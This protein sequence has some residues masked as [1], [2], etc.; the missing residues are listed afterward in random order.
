MD[1][2]IKFI[3]RLTAFL[4]LFFILALGIERL[5]DSPD[6]QNFSE[7]DN[8]HKAL[9]DGADIIYFGDSA[10]K[11][12]D[13]NDVDMR[14]MAQ[15]LEDLLNGKQELITN[16]V[17]HYK[18]VNTSFQSGRFDLFNISGAI[19]ASDANESPFKYLGQTFD[20]NQT[21]TTRIA[22]IQEPTLFLSKMN[23]FS[24][25]YSIYVYRKNMI[26]SHI[27][28]RRMDEWGVGYAS[29]IF[30]KRFRFV[31][32][33]SEGIQVVLDSLKRISDETWYD[34]CVVRD[35]SEL[36]IRMYV[37]GKLDNAVPDN[38]K[39]NLY[40]D[41]DILYVGAGENGTRLFFNG[42]I[43][44]LLI[45]N[46]SLSSKEVLTIPR[47]E[48]KEQ[49]NPIIKQK[50]QSNISLGDNISVHDVSYAGYHLGLFEA[51]IDDIKSYQH[52]P[53][54]IIIPINMKLFSLPWVTFPHAQF[55][56]EINIIRNSQQNSAILTLWTRIYYLFS[57]NLEAVQKENEKW[58]NE[59]IY[60]D[61]KV[62][63]TAKDCVYTFVSKDAKNKADLNYKIENEFICRY[64][65]SLNLTNRRLRSLDTL[66]RTC[67][68]SGITPII[69]I[70]P[71][72]YDIGL[73]YQGN[74]SKERIEENINK[75]L[76]IGEKHHITIV[77]MA[78]DLHTKDFSAAYDPNAHLKQ[79]G[80]FH[81]AKKLYNHIM[82]TSFSS[83]KKNHSN[84]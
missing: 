27:F 39:T 83:R 23:N 56:Q 9:D 4:L 26:N 50:T 75:V 49:L 62:I 14:S 71:L 47:K 24:I 41:D 10:N 36:K 65:Y 45:I 8:L 1:D 38:T 15:M 72:N 51:F 64:L 6:I 17:I 5:I 42:L 69:Y 11:F 13:K 57:L 48:R 25:C 68:N 35:S 82:P 44:D 66:I 58:G 2:R 70:T 3:R 80:R 33:D 29:M 40:R 73:H 61:G 30:A 16:K 32:E 52:K 43:A 77:N 12:F 74:N 37:N 76:S 53:K 84:N 63:G 28:H 59:L 31:I 67:K 55:D 81:I 18:L 20:P 78:F 79:Q 21:L 22:H 54:Y 60:Y 7:L 46:K 34:I 19:P